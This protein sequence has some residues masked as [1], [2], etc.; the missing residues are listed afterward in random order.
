MDRE[1]MCVVLK[2]EEVFLAWPVPGKPGFIR[3]ETKEEQTMRLKRSRGN[4]LQVD[5]VPQ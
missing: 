2:P 1:V 4:V 3:I 5:S